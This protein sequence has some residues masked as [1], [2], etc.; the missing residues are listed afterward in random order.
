MVF[1]RAKSRAIATPPMFL[2]NGM[3]VLSKLPFHGDYI[4]GIDM[5]CLLDVKQQTATAVAAR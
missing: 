5:G 3:N 2:L 1:R 4:D